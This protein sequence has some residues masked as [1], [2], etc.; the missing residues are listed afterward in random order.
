MYTQHTYEEGDE[1][2]KQ[3]YGIVLNKEA[4]YFANAA[5]VYAC[6]YRVRISRS[7]DPG[8]TEYCFMGIRTPLAPDIVCLLTTKYL[9]DMLHC[10]EHKM[11]RV[12]LCFARQGEIDWTHLATK[13][14]YPFLWYDFDTLTPY[15]LFRR[16]LSLLLIRKHI[17]H[18]WCLRLVH[19]QTFKYAVKTF[20]SNE[21]AKM[22]A[23]ATAIRLGKE[24]PLPLPYY[25]AVGTPT[26][27]PTNPH[28]LH[29]RIL[30]T[31]IKIGK[32]FL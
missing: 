31:E 23:K 14:T 5:Y 22:E 27:P 8:V 17:L 11:F 1:S 12:M 32:K 25:S 18:S 10:S 3:L 24:A 16:E 15:Y 28:L 9:M 21:Q 29:L 30:P 13:M 26:T 2:F 7:A 4:L 6:R 20:H 19:R